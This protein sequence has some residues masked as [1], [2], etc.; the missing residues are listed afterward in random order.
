MVRRRVGVRGLAA[1]VGDRARLD[2]RLVR[3]GIMAAMR[4]VVPSDEAVGAGVSAG[5]IAREASEERRDHCGQR[6]TQEHWEVQNSQQPQR[7]ITKI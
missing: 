3:K 1:G 4:R 2:E 7:P 6:Q 5:A